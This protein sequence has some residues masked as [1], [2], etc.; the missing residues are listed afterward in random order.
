[1]AQTAQ[2]TQAAQMTQIQNVMS[3]TAHIIYVQLDCR[4]ATRTYKTIN[5]LMNQKGYDTIETTVGQL[6]ARRIQIYP[7][8][9]CLGIFLKVILN[10][11]QN[12]T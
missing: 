8:Y 1:M 11:F 7:D 6:L 9:F 10:N 3:Q 2:K 12:N 4:I 5:L